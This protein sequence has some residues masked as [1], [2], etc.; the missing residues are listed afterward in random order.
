MNPL[1][2]LKDIQLPPEVSN[3]PPAYGWWLVAIFFLALLIFTII[4]LLKWHHKRLAKRHGLI[5]LSNIRSDDEDWP[6]QLNSLLKRAAIAYFPDY[7]VAQMHGVKWNEFLVQQ[8]PLKK[9]SGFEADFAV[10]QAHLYQK[11]SCDD[12]QFNQ[13]MAAAKFWMNKALPPKKQKTQVQ[14]VTHV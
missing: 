3:W 14:E 11:V 13:S 5:E 6:I 12:K 2:Q 4:W 7:K 1:D 8:L 10:I 9:R